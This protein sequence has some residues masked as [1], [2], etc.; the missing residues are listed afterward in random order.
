MYLFIIDFL[1]KLMIVACK[2]LIKKYRAK[3]C[4]IYLTIFKD[5]TSNNFNMEYLPKGFTHFKQEIL[6]PFR[7][8]VIF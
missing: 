2:Y 8:E 7:L 3:W 6:N 4:V 1:I 5:Y